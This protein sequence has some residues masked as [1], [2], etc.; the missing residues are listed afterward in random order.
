MDCDTGD[1]DVGGPSKGSGGAS[2]RRSSG[3]SASRK[4]ATGG[5]GSASGRRSSGPKSSDK[6]GSNAAGGIASGIGGSG[7]GAT[8]V[9][10]GG[11]SGSFEDGDTFGGLVLRFPSAIDRWLL[12]RLREIRRTRVPVT[13]TTTTTATAAT[14]ATAPTAVTASATTTTSATAPATTNPDSP[15]VNLDPGKD[16]AIQLVIFHALLH[17]LRFVPGCLFALNSDTEIFNRPLYLSECC[18]T[19]EERGF[20][21]G[22]TPLPPPPG[23]IY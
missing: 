13:E 14:A 21:T 6:S 22:A 7:T 20:M 11:G 12:T 9:G 18:R 23:S 19:L 10:T 8:G 5:G 16:T 17:L 2:G 3:S 15:L 1:I 4:M